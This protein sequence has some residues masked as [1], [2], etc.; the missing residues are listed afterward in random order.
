MS[1]SLVL[2]PGLDGTGELFEPLLDELPSHIQPMVMR[3]PVRGDQ[4]YSTL[5][6]RVLEHLPTDR[7]FVLLG[8]SFS[9][10]VAVLVAA[11]EP[12]GLIGIILCA[13]FVISPRRC[14]GLLASLSGLAPFYGLGRVAAPFIV[15][16]RSKTAALS[17]LLAGAVENIPHT[18][19]GARYRAVANVD[20]R[21]EL[22]QLKLPILYMQAS[23]DLVVP[24]A[25]GKVVARTSS[26]V[27]VKVI[28][29]PHF[30]LQC[31]PAPAADVIDAFVREIS[32]IAG[33]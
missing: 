6:Q 4:A 1:V 17:R 22:S 32:R 7:R 15:M 27:T 8:E 24:A 29:A 5:A 3:Y 18:I 2:L 31:A 25:A 13:S 9:G 11:A 19:F 26:L 14:V 28:A 21:S 33:R 10:P 23:A 30:L 12:K 20:V 16:G